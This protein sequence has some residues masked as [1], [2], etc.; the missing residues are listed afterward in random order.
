MAEPDVLLQRRLVPR[1]WLYINFDCNLSCDYCVVDSHPGCRR[2][3]LDRDDC[4]ELI[5]EAAALGFRQVVITGGEPCLHPD[6]I[7]ILRHSSSRLPTVM[8]TNATLLRTRRLM[9]LK[10]IVAGNLTMQVSLDSASSPLHDLHRGPGSWQAA[11]DGLDQL[12]EW[13]FD[14]IV[15]ATTSVEGGDG[16]T[17]L[18]KFLRS[19]GISEERSYSMPIVRGGR[20]RTGLDLR[21]GDLPPEPAVAAD[22]LYWHPLKMHPSERVAAGARLLREGLDRLALL[23]ESAGQAASASGY[24]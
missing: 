5:E 16:D 20:A 7:P 18:R 21:T 13:G 19:R 23:A 22:G 11:V 3:R 4:R 9:A 15:R 24:R 2:P 17:V 8:L 14:V 1:I 10:E 6:I 12:L